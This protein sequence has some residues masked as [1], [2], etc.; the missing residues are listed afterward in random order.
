[1]TPARLIRCLAV[2]IAFCGLV[3]S[4]L[5]DEPAQGH[6]RFHLERAV[7]AW[8]DQDFHRVVDELQSIDVSRTS[9]FSGSSR[10]AF[11]LA[12][13]WIR[14][15]DEPA[16]REVARAGG[17]PEGDPWRRWVAW[18]GLTFGEPASVRTDEGAS[19]L[20]TAHLLLES[21]DAAGAAALLD[22]TRVPGE[23]EALRLHLLATSRNESGASARD[24][25]SRLAA[26]DPGNPL[27]TE[28]VGDAR[29]ALAIL[30][31]EDG[32]SPEDQLRDI[33]TGAT[34]RTRGL[35]LLALHALE[36]GDRDA[37]LVHL[38]EL[39]ARDDPGPL[40]RE[41]LLLR[42]SLDMDE[43]NFD[44][45]LER[46]EAAEQSFHREQE[47]LAALASGELTDSAWT[48]WRR[49]TAR[50]FVP[51][52]ASALADAA[53]TRAL[54]LSSDEDDL[55]LPG[56]E[57]STGAGHQFASF[58]PTDTELR[59]VAEVRA[60]RQALA[61][62][63]SRLEASI[64][65]AEATAGRRLRYLQL[66]TSHTGQS[67][68]DMDGALRELESHLRDLERT[69]AQ[70]DSV[71][72]DAT[73]EIVDR[74]RRV[75]DELDRN[76]LFIKALTHFHVDGPRRDDPSTVRAL[77][78]AETA[79]ASELAGLA[80]TFGTAMTALVDRSFD[81]HL[82][83]RVSGGARTLHAALLLERER[84]LRL[85]ADL[86]SL[87]ASVEID[88]ALYAQRD[89]LAVV[90]GR[91]ADEESE[92]KQRIVV[93]VAGR[94]RARLDS[95]RE[96]LDYH[97]ADA[98]F[99]RAVEL[100]LDPATSEDAEVLRPHRDRAI[101]RL[102]S[103]L[104]RHPDSFARADARFRLAD[105]HLLRARDEFQVR[106][107]GFLGDD[108][109]T[110][111]ADDRSLA[112]FVETTAS[113]ALYHLILDEDPGFAHRDAV[114]YSLGMILADDGDPEGVARL[115][116]LVDAYPA[117][118]HAQE[119]WLRLGTERFD[120][121]D[122]AGAIPSLEAAARG[123]DPSFT[124]IALYQLGWSHFELDRFSAAADDFRQLMDLYR[125]HEDLAASTDL[126]DEAEEY[127]V[128]SLARGGGAD[129]FAR[130]FDRLGGRDYEARI[131][132]GMG[133][134]LK[135]FSL[136]EESIACDQLWLDRYPTNEAALAIARRMVDSYASD[137]RLP[138]AREARL[139]LAPRFM[140]GGDW[141]DTHPERDDGVEFARETWREAATHWHEA[142]RAS[143]AS[144]DWSRALSLYE[145][146]LAHWPASR[147]NYQAGE[148]ASKLGDY[149]RA[150][151]HFSVAA[152]V[153]AA[154]AEDAAW[155]KVAAADQWY[156]SAPND[157]LAAQVLAFGD[158]FLERVPDSEQAADLRWR[159]AQLAY[160][161][162]MDAADRFAAMARF[163]PRDAR[164]PRG[165]RLRGDALHRDG[166]LRAAALAYE[167][168]LAA[169]RTA[170]QDSLATD[171]AAVIPTSWYEHAES[172]ATSESE[173]AAADAFVDVARRFPDYQHADKALY[174]AGLGYLDLEQTDPAV[175]AFE[176]I[177]EV[178]PES[179]FARDASIRIAQSL[180]DDGRG[181]EAALAWASFSRAFPADPDA[182]SALMK[183]VD[184]FAEL[185][186][187]QRAEGLESEFLDRY[188]GETE[189]VMEIRASR[190]RR[191]L[192]RSGIGL[193]AAGT[194]AD[195]TAYLELAETHP[196]LASPVIL[197]EVDFLRADEMREE[198]LQLR[199][200]QPL[201]ASI[202]AKKDQ[203]ERLL[204]AYGQCARRQVSTWAHASAYRIGEILVAFGDA[205]L[206]SERPADLNADE[207]LAYD[208]V[209]DEQSWTFHDRGEEA[210]NELLR[211]NPP[212]SSDP[213]AWLERTRGELWP[214]VARRF[215]H[216]PA[217][218]YPVLEAEP[219]ASE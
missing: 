96:A 119:A 72:A 45:A 65:E 146:Y 109:G 25:W 79:L 114:L 100:T 70:M 160:A 144:T 92:L 18:R 104:V 169:A 219:P 196:E 20:L 126:R 184:A 41:A 53:V 133:A 127:L 59:S 181:Q 83:P 77:L 212:G 140:T 1:M 125:E 168:A 82:E 5:A 151:A 80:S 11:L 78:V 137:G 52:E 199:L 153:T 136:Y 110:S 33:P 211:Q 102:D 183:S 189:T 124:A 26:R 154:F 8:A 27:D 39:V 10:A 30:Q 192:D 17:D 206:D 173:A 178:H 60:R 55:S 156:M 99:E 51:A 44:A 47:F 155:Q 107:A 138:E 120:V 93:D 46:F 152:T 111:K 62:E 204:E 101:V 98:A 195:L 170:G 143:N 40:G 12:E 159:Q 117:S 69:L 135:S 150:I 207:L 157:T 210:W 90:A 3:T 142:A 201:E 112:P 81:E 182:P 84:A 203:L 94:G 148:A 215:L 42:G 208:E 139:A 186:D 188:P 164:A 187:A 106:M 202:E 75:I 85:S 172:I 88:P 216:Q 29:L 194:S 6:D 63:Q 15:G 87:S 68:G 7:A 217:A 13:A 66:G 205:L 23:L 2:A 4:A 141:H 167:D 21:G 213:G 43:E 24:I 38:D 91:L 76:R 67:L 130:Y 64:D 116:E 200:T 134:L 190:A 19:A 50:G 9:T 122:F 61:A 32:A 166:D 37:A 197:A 123:D 35:M 185:G 131:L 95:E 193:L 158:A 165:L 103:F 36:E 161:H 108:A 71:Q 171:L 145:T 48:A 214:R 118:P 74:T 209:L 28:L 113:V 56:L 89:S 16:C 179:A 132:S 86:D 163:H 121:K 58:N 22:D 174:R 49:P 14:L 198:Y 129:E 218:T 177:L 73:R 191:E 31:F 175:E 147:M 105:L 34:A 54:D 180:E 149:E 97:L 57:T 176:E 162:D 115:T 128:H